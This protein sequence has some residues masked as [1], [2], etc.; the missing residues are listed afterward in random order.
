MNLQ[1]ERIATMCTSSSS[2]GSPPSGRRWRRRRR[3]M[4]RA[5][6]EFLERLLTI[7]NDARGRAATPDAAEARHSAVGQDARAV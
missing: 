6:A 1:H 7:E 2:S 4:K 5:Y 3:A